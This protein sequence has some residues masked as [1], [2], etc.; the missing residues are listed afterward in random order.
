MTCFCIDSNMATSSTFVS[1]PHVRQTAA[2]IIQSAVCRTNTFHRP[3]PTL[4]Y[5]PGLNTGPVW[6]KNQ[7]ADISAALQK[8]Y[9]CIVKEYNTLKAA[10][11][12]SDY[13][14]STEDQH[15]KLHSGKWDWRSYI[16]KGQ[17]QANFA[18]HCPETVALL[19]SFQSPSLMSGTPFS[20]AFFSTMHAQSS[21]SP[22]S[23]P[24]NL[25]LR[26][27]FPLSVPRTGDFGVR[28]ADQVIQW[29][30]GE[31]LFFDDSYEHEVWNRTDEERVILLFDMW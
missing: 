10:Q 19:E 5:F 16:L 9:D 23:G 25:R 3:N 7:F 24:C 28:V 26:C 12:Q 18:V 8:N 4:F 22:H 6:H 29:Q 20:F 15:S 14:S 11:S 21:I 27:H 1:G 13:D 30:A 2:K 31:P 17:R